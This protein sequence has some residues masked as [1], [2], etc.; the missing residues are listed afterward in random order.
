MFSSPSVGKVACP[1]I[2]LNQ[3]E[4]A[5]SLECRFQQWG[6]GNYTPG[7]TVLL[8]LLG[9][10]S[11]WSFSMENFVQWTEFLDFHSEMQ[12]LQDLSKG[13]I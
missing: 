13:P 7:L 10:L 2:N 12:T 9:M 5:K 3:S 4:E 6:L 8:I 11:N 1:Q